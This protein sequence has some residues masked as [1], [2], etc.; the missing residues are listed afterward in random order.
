M[1][2]SKLNRNWWVTLNFYIWYS[3]NFE[4]KFFVV[5]VVSLRACNLLPR[6]SPT[7]MPFKYFSKKTFLGYLPIFKNCH[8]LLNFISSNGDK[9]V[10]IYTHKFTC[11]CHPF[12]IFTI[13]TKTLPLD[14]ACRVWDMFCRDGDIFLF[15]TALGKSCRQSSMHTVESLP[16]FSLS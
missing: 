16:L 1:H 2:F 10:F 11:W 4:A 7:L 13:Y 5:L 12:R 6:W 8:F 15:R 14:V 9:F 3:V